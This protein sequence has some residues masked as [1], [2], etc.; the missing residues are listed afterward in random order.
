MPVFKKC[1]WIVIVV[2]KLFNRVW[3]PKQSKNRANLIVHTFTVLSVQL[4]G[5]LSILQFYYEL[6]NI[7]WN[8]EYYYLFVLNYFPNSLI[9]HRVRLTTIHKN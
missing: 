9:N 2:H 8:I 4:I 3:K 6:V 7:I 1:S 5:F